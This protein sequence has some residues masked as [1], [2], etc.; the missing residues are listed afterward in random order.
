MPPRQGS[1]NGGVSAVE[2][3]D[4]GFVLAARRHG[5]SAV[6]IQSLTE[7]HG[8][9]AGLVRGGA[10]RRFKGVLQPGNQVK[11][12][13]R[14]RLAEHLGHFTVEP[15]GAEAS[16]LIGDRRRL[17]A[18]A[19]ACALLESQL[20]ERAPHPALYHGTRSLLTIMADGSDRAESGG[21]DLSWLP[22]YVRWEIGLLAEI[23]FGL[24]LSHC[25]LT[26]AT[27]GLAWVS[28][29]TGRAVTEA[30]AGDYAR[31]LL[32]LPAFLAGAD[33]SLAGAGASLQDCVD[34]LRLT[35][36]FLAAAAGGAEHLPAARDRFVEGIARFH[37]T[38]CDKDRP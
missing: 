17:G 4:Q 8:R 11:L 22:A 1:S 21:G 28:P 29:R 30:A 19:S 13:W 36:H 2:W 6:I 20:P 14:G 26:G 31:R 24:A 35:R 15:A 38:S 10:S 25:A 3:A 16:L 23:G 5:E 18:L 37:T 7:N 9:H 34:G 33:R 32:R 12:V 27:E